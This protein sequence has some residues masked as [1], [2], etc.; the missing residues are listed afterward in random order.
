MSCIPAL[1]S[2]S[3]LVYK[4]VCLTPLSHCIGKESGSQRPPA[5]EGMTYRVVTD[6]CNNY[7]G[8]Y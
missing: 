7:T 8:E 6:L 3:T 4:S 1:T 2:T 5:G